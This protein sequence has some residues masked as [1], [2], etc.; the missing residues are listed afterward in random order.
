LTFVFRGT[1]TPG[2]VHHIHCLQCTSY[3]R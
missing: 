1:G 2:K 3:T